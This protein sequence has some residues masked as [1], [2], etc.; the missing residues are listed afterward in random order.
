MQNE[1]NGGNDEGVASILRNPRLRGFGNYAGSS[2]RARQEEPQRRKQ[3]GQYPILLF[4]CT[5]FCFAPTENG[6]VQNE[7][8]V[9]PLFFSVPLRNNG[10][11]NLCKSSVSAQTVHCID[12][13][14]SREQKERTPTE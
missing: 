5:Y 10:V 4:C 11:D 1:K 14:Q 8:K 9:L 2:V 12:W 6:R 7:E 3:Y 13:G